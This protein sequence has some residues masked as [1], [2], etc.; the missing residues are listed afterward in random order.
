[1]V[2][3]IPQTKKEF[4]SV[5][6]EVLRDNDYG[7][8]SEIKTLLTNGRMDVAEPLIIEYDLKRWMNTSCDQTDANMVCKPKF[9]KSYKGI[10]RV[11]DV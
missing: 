5:L 11:K 6:L 7:W 1:M 9:Q 3:R 2:Y 4:V 10:E 8:A